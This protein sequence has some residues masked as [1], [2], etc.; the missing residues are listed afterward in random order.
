[1]SVDAIEPALRRF[2]FAHAD[3][4]VVPA[5]ALDRHRLR[6]DLAHAL[7]DEGRASPAQL[8]CLEQGFRL[9]W[10]RCADLFARAPGAWFP[11]RQTNLLVVAEPRGVVPYLEPFAGTS[12]LLYLADL[13]THP[14]YVAVLLLHMERL[15]LMRSVRA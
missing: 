5:E 3:A 2:C 9:Y 8:R 1:M 11:P 6:D 7:A 15:A 4:F 10:E 14:E 12:S 13:D